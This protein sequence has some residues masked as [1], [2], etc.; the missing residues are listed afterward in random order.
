MIVRRE[1]IATETPV[2]LLPSASAAQ[3]GRCVGQRVEMQETAEDMK[4][5]TSCY[6]G[7]CC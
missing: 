5:F 4:I 2:V 6:G 7:H 1:Y 3:A